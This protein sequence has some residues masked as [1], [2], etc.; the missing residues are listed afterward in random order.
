MPVVPGND[1]EINYKIDGEGDETVLL[2]NGVGDDLAAWADQVTDFV[3]AGLRVVSFDNRGVG[4]SSCPA[5]PYT[6]AQMAADTK[7]LADALG[8][9]PFHLV[10]VSMGGAIAQ[11]YALAHPDDLNSVVLANTYARPDPFSFAAF[12]VW[13]QIAAAAGMPVMMRQMAPW[14]FGPAFYSGRPAQLAACLA[15]MERTTQPTDA[16]VAQIAALVNHDC[17]DRISQLQMPA[18]VIAAES[19][20]IIR[21]ALSR[22]L[23]DG[24][25]DARWVQLPGGHA[26]FI[27]DPGPWNRAV[28][29]FVTDHRSNA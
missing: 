16:F 18:L 26:G 17:Q 13:G 11:E 27:E 5:G 21:P 7:A 23:F 25:P 4:R 2:V 19:D 10:G 20:I 29:E 6:G 22:Q 1:I 9:A 28:I 3:A 8:L 14:V 15:E 12:D 24:L